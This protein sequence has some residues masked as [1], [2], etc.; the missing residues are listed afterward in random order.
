[1]ESRGRAHAPERRILVTG[2]S[3]FVGA[4]LCRRLVEAG[5][6]VHAVSRSPRREGQSASRWWNADLEEPGLCDDLVRAVDPD[7][8]LHL[9]GH[10]TGN[11]G[12][13]AVLPTF[14][15]NLSATVELL[16]AAARHGVGRIVLAGSLEETDPRDGVT[17]PGSPYAAAKSAGT[18]YAQMLHALHALPVVILRIFMVYGPAQ[19]DTVK[20]VPYVIRSLLRG[21]PPELSDGRRPVDWIYVDDVVEAFVIAAS[22]PGVDGATVDVGTGR[23]TTIRD[24]VEQLALLLDPAAELRFGARPNPAQE[25]VAVADADRSERLLG[26]R[27]VVPLDEGLRRTVDWYR[28][29]PGD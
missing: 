29:A 27:A 3:G 5:A 24:V 1:M 4:H 13:D 2:A 16:T 6:T 23:L 21:E 14:R 8:V 19:R 15:A 12:L 10:V 18:A 22:A 26:W 25:R 11:R 28:R 17:V 7:I 9:A 20:L